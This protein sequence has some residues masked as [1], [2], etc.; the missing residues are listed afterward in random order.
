VLPDFLHDGRG[1][2][3]PSIG[4]QGRDPFDVASRQSV[5]AGVQLPFDHRCVRRDPALLLNQEVHA[6][7]GMIE[8]LG[9][10]RVVGV[11][12][13]GVEECTER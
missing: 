7:E 1:E 9:R 5:A 3:A 8:V 11:R 6:S 4:R 2:P 12:P 10:E 13:R